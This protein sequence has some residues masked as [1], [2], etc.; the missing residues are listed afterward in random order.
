MVATFKKAKI[1]IVFVICLMTLCL[2]HFEANAETAPQG[3]MD[4]AR[5][6]LYPFLQRIS[7]DKFENYGFTAK[8]SLDNARLGSPFRVYTITPSTLFKY[9]SG[10]TVSS[11]ISSTGMWYFPIMV[12][13]DMR[14]ILTVS[15]L[16]GVWKAVAMGQTSLARELG[17]VVRQWPRFKGYEPLLVMVF[18]AKSY[19]F[20]VPE[21][22]DYN[23]TPFTFERKDFGLE[24]RK[25]DDKYSTTLDLSGIINKLK[26]DVEE[27]VRQMNKSPN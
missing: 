21:K 8:D 20:T 24:S 6:G 11:L 5:N 23:L 25:S 3:V 12:D 2:V 13:N 19:F 15:R 16:N 4:A 9:K 18:Q 14:A 22:D 17:V 1:C 27:N 7:P 10:D 26:T